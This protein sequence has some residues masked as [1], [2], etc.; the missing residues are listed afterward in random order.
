[1][2]P[3]RS[4]RGWIPVILLLAWVAGGCDFRVTRDR[5]TFEDLDPHEKSV[6]EI[7]LDELR[8]FNAQVESRTDLSIAKVIDR[9]RI[10]VS[11]EGHIF[12]GNLGDD[13]IHVAPWENLSSGQQE[14][15]QTWFQASTPASAKATYEKLF[16]RFLTVSQGAKQYMYEALTAEWVYSNRSLYNVERDTIR[17]TLS[18]YKTIGKQTEMWN[19][20]TNACKPILSQYAEVYGPSFSKAYLTA[21]FQELANPKAPT[22]YMYYIC[23]WVEIGKVD[24]VSL[25]TELLWVQDLPSLRE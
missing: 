1:M 6:V 23:R 24:A 18:Y 22:G 12:S 9:E 14:L 19:F 5:P 20:A 7:V 2:S 4:E 17:E 11:F 15:V 3:S 16:Y 8:G 10:N 21:H 25:T 13:I